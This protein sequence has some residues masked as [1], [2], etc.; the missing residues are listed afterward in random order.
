MRKIT[1]MKVLWLYF[2]L[3]FC[4]LYGEVMPGKDEFLIRSGPYEITISTRYAFTMTS[5][6][7]NGKLVGGRGGFYGTIFCP[8]PGK[9]IGAGHTEGGAE[10]IS[11][12]RLNINGEDLKPESNR[13][14]EGK[15]VVMYK[16]SLLANLELVET[17]EV[18]A[19]GIIITRT[20]EA[21][22]DQQAYSLYTY[23]FCWVSDTKEWVAE[24]PDGRI[25][26]GIFLS[27]DSWRL[28][29]DI[30]WTGIYHPLSQTGMLVYYPEVIP[31]QQRKSCYW[32]KEA[33]H[34]YYLMMKIPTFLPKGSKLG[35][36]TAIIKGFNSPAEGWK[37][38]AIEI[39]RSFK[40]GI[41]GGAKKEENNKL[42]KKISSDFK[43]DFIEWNSKKYLPVFHLDL[44]NLNEKKVVDNISGI[45]GNINGSVVSDQEG[46]HFDGKTTYISLEKEKIN[47]LLTGSFIMVFKVKVFA[48]ENTYSSYLFTQRVSQTD[49]GISFGLGGEK[50]NPGRLFLTV[51]SGKKGVVVGKN[52]KTV[53]LNQWVELKVC[54]DK[55]KKIGELYVENELVGKQVLQLDDISKDNPVYIGAWIGPNIY[56]F[57]GI[58]K[59]IFIYNPEIHSQKGEKGEIDMYRESKKNIEEWAINRRGIE[60]LDENFV[61]P[62]FIPVEA[63]KKGIVKVWGRRYFFN[64]FGLIK[65][66]EI[67]S[68]SFFNKAMD[69]ELVVNGVDIPFKEPVLTME[70]EKKGKVI[71]SSKA[72]GN[73]DVKLEIQTSVEYDGM[74][75]VDFTIIPEKKIKLNSF[76]YRIY[77]PQNNVRFLRYDGARLP[78]ESGNI[79][80][81][82]YSMSIPDEKGVIW[83]A[84]FKTLIWMGDFEKGF[85]WFCSSEQNWNPQERSSRPEAIKIIKNEKEVVLEI[86]PVSSDYE[87]SKAVTYTFG[88]FA[89]P[90][91][92]L[93]DGWRGWNQVYS[94]TDDIWSS[95]GYSA[96]P[97][98]LYYPA[99]LWAEVPFYPKMK[100]RE[101]LKK[102]VQMK[103]N[104]GK[105]V[106]PYIDPRLMAAGILKNP[107]VDVGIQWEMPD[108]ELANID[109][110]SDESMF[111][112]KVPEIKYY[113][114]WRTEPPVVT[115]YEREKGH[116]QFEVASQS[117]WADLLCYFIEELAKNGVRGIADLDEW[118]Y[119]PNMNPLNNAGYIDDKGIRR[120]D[121]DIFAK[122][123][124]MK[125]IYYIF[126]KETGR[127]P[128]I[129]AHLAATLCIPF[130]SHF[131][132][133][134]TGEHFNSGYYIRNDF[135]GEYFKN[136]DGL[137]KCLK[138][139]GE[140]WYYYVAPLDRIQAELI[141]KQFGFAVMVMGQTRKD[142]N[143]RE[144]IGKSKRVSR[145]LLALTALHDT[146]T[147][148]IFCDPEP[149]YK[150]WD[151]REKF[152]IT[153]KEVVFYPYWLEKSPFISSEKD[154]YISAY[155]NKNKWLV[156]AANLSLKDIVSDI[157]IKGDCS[158]IISI[159]DA[160]TNEV[161]PH[162]NNKIKISIPKRDVRFIVIE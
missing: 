64:P 42:D 157:T 112:W 75:R 77:Y 95:L 118:N 65:D 68:Q 37:N 69:F 138:E 156:I 121:Y 84:P 49:S 3:F 66:V 113:K 116:I 133:I 43:K 88:M 8:S 97:R 135:L 35:P 30:K 98:I 94:A 2:I 1:L 115:R 46:L 104:E 29:E 140:N 147:W 86:N 34:K 71:F 161:I 26:D 120:F 61:P 109:I 55:E 153:D 23:Q 158:N 58:I 74:V 60:A 160:E 45:T 146:I 114:E 82:S 137:Y 6:Y 72:V 126:L 154:I 13:I 141:G 12:I 81:N 128:I 31:G 76:K 129:V 91:R 131:S 123:D 9:Y 59:E 40:Q 108:F 73:Q 47:E 150:Y 100:D 136:S 50:N 89:T 92:P 103:R 39:A 78:L 41:E 148:P 132:V 111:K 63:D 25:V 28:N 144:D 162:L 87:I 151:I 79:P 122:R 51:G 21:K 119:T 32:D 36:Y 99:H 83:K 124:L 143:I 10:E 27:D 52:E 62:P 14:Y 96:I 38:S 16:V 101:G 134:L 127:E 57:T 33:Y 152:G 44:C 7:F 19:E 105:E 22:E 5:I 70:R 102:Y 90:V 17:T 20:Y 117:G 18:S 125:R 67:N 48:Y 54:Y 4:C 130:S 107:E 159:K 139:G 56:Y 110:N 53:P 145:E 93:P 85:L 106:M 11:S 15:K 24:L 80:R 155:F 142:K 149:F